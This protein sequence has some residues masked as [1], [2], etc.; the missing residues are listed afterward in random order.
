MKSEQVAALARQLARVRRS[1]AAESPYGPA[2][3][4]TTEWVDDLERQIRALTVA[5]DGP[6]IEIALA[7]GTAHLLVA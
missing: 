4:A 3:A 2:W 1:L 6:A 5:P 7:S